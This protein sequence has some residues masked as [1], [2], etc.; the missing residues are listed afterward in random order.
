MAR[1]QKT[2]DSHSPDDTK[3]MAERLASTLEQG[4]CILL[5]GDIGAGK[6][7][8]ARSLIQKRLLDRGLSEDVPSPT[9]TIVQVYDDG[10]LEIW[11]ADLYRISRDG[12]LDELGLLE[13]MEDA[14]TVIEW[15]E[16]VS[17]L[18]QETSLSVKF[19]STKHPQHRTIFVS[20]QNPKWQSFIE[21]L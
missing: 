13:A 10:E 18:V 14:A 5:F 15:P 3:R 16:R 1:F 19:E 8:F 12:E 2:I 7:H 21:S 11:H 17:D 20:S 9:F 4:D 6:S